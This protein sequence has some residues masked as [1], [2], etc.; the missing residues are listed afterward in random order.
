MTEPAYSYTSCFKVGD[1]KIGIL[2]LNSAWMCGQRIVEGE[3]NDYGALIL[4]EPQFLDPL[5]N[6]ELVEA[7]I[8]IALI[9]HPFAWFS[10]VEGRTYIQRCITRSVHF[11][12]RGHEHE[13]QVSIPS[14]TGGSH[15]VIS[16]GACYDRREY[17]NGYN[18]VHIDFANN[19]GT[20]FLRRYDLN[21]NLFQKD[22]VTTG[23]DSPGYHEFVLPNKAL[24]AVQKA[25]SAVQTA[26]DVH[27]VKDYKDPEVLKALEIYEE[28]IPAHERFEA[29]DILRWL[30]EDEEQRSQSG[31]GPWDY[32][33]VASA[34][35][36]VCGFTLVHYYPA[37]QL[38]FVAYLVA[39]KGVSRRGRQH[40]AQAIR[41]CFQLVSAR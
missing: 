7:D 12:L 28:R 14:G 6:P 35:G 25:T 5:Q 1:K 40:L 19:R 17:A 13:S 38:A 26:I 22:T 11:V 36:R 33:V 27:L 20:V 15:A 3:V 18:F 37:L 16:A 29:P 10:D 9:H 8:S 32:F 34:N 39:E 23:D 4:G 41:I 24:K 2:G 31:T 21:T 30:R